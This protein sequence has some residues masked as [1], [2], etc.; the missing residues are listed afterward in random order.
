MA[1]KWQND[2][3]VTIFWHDVIVKFFWCCFISLVKFSYLSKFHVDIITG[4]RVTTISFYKGLTRNPETENTPVW[5]LPNIW[6]LDWVMNTKLCTN[7]S[8]K[9]LLNAAKCQGC[10]FYCFWVIKRK[11]TGGEVKLPPTQIRVKIPSSSSLSLKACHALSNF[12]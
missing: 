9:I 4:S 7:V 5:V 11:P 10:S 6:R 1:I 12:R 8:I 2:S 3:E